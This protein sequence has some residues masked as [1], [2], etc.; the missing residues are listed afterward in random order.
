[1]ANGKLHVWEYVERAGEGWGYAGWCAIPLEKVIEWS[2][3]PLPWHV[4]TKQTDT[5]FYRFEKWIID[6]FSKAI[7]P[8]VSVLE[9][10]FF[11]PLKTKNDIAT[12]MHAL[13]QQDGVKNYSCTG[14]VQ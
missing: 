4:T 10:G 14:G 13:A 6:H 11:H 5:P 3:E 8:C 1:M 12:T 2:K 7:K 9:R